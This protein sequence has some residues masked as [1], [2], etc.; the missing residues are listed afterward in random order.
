MVISPMV[1]IPIMP[2]VVRDWLPASNGQRCNNARDDA[3][4]AVP[5][6]LIPLVI[7]H[8]KDVTSNIVPSLMENISKFRIHRSENVKP[9]SEGFPHQFDLRVS[10]A[11][12]TKGKA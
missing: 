5:K 4:N 10:V 6:N 12:V 11:T 1:G 8:N 7:K 9:E 2:K 3:R